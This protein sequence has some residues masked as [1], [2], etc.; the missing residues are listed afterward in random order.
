MNEKGICYRPKL[1]AADI[2]PQNW[3]RYNPSCRLSWIERSSNSSCGGQI[4][5]KTFT[6]APVAM[7]I[8]RFELSTTRRCVPQSRVFLENRIAEAKKAKFFGW[9]L[10]NDDSDLDRSGRIRNLISYIQHWSMS[11]FDSEWRY[12]NTLAKRVQSIWASIGAADNTTSTFEGVVTFPVKFCGPV[13]IAAL[14]IAQ[15]SQEKWSL[16]W[17]LL[18]RNSNEMRQATEASCPVVAMHSQSSRVL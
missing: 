2:C 9:L 1:S 5:A 18:T 16:T 17:C 7:G 10:W 12:A 13:T 11:Q 4:L 3:P 14:G 15:S 8:E 6:A